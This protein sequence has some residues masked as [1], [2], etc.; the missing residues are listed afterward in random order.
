MMDPNL[1]DYYIIDRAVPLIITIE[2][3]YQFDFGN[4][5]CFFLIITKLLCVWVCF[6]KK[7]ILNVHD[8]FR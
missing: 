4:P 7:L 3:R 8:A 6:V 1:I 2:Y 5:A